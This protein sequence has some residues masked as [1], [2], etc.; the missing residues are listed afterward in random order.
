M[1]RRHGC[2]LYLLVGLV[3]WTGHAS[4]ETPPDFTSEEKQWIKD[5]PVVLFATEP[6]F[7]PV[8][9][10]ENG[11]HAGIVAEYLKAIAKQSGLRFQYVPTKNWEEAQRA[12]REG[13]V[14]LL[15]NV[16]IVRLSTETVHQTLLTDPYY[17]T[18]TVIVTQGDKPVALN[19]RSLDGKVIATTAAYAYIM[20]HR[21]PHATIFPVLDS[22]SALKAVSEGKAEAAVGTEVV[23]APMLR[24]KYAGTMGVAGSLDD[25]P[26]VASMGVRRDEPLLYS[27]MRKS[28]GNL[29]AVETDEM[30]E[31][32]LGQVDYG[33]PSII[34]ILRYRTPELAILGLFIGLLGVFA[35][36]T[37]VA[38]RK[39]EKSE[40]AKSRFLAVMSHEIR[41]PMNAVLASIEMLLRT[42]LDR[43]QQLFA[44]TA[45][46]AA[47]SLLS[48]LDD[49]L[50][51]SKLDAQRLDL[52]RVP[53]DVGALALNVAD[54]VRTRAS[55]KDIAVNV[56]IDNPHHLD[57]LIDPTRFRQVVLNLLT[58]ALKFTEHG[59]ITVS[60]KVAGIQAG[61]GQGNLAV[62]VSDTGIG[63]APDQQARLFQA[64]TQ[65]DSSTT[66][67]YGGT[68]LGLT[69]CKELVELMGGHIKLDSAVGI[70]T[71][72]SFVL[73]V[74][75][76]ERAVPEAM[77]PKPSP[78]HDEV[79]QAEAFEGTVL[80][81]DDHPD[82][83]FVIGEQLRD[84]GIKP[85]SVSDGQAALRAIK[86]QS[87]ALV[88]M[89]C[90]MPEMDGYKTTQRI[91]DYEAA[92]HLA[93]LPVIAIS[94]ATDAAHQ[95]T[96]MQS[97]MD[98]ILT[99]PLR[100]NELH[101]MLQMWL[102]DLPP[103]P[104][105]SEQR[106]QTI[107]RQAL[108]RAALLEDA[109]ALSHALND[110]DGK[111][112]GQLAHRIKGAASIANLNDIGRLAEQLETVIHSNVPDCEV[113]A[114]QIWSRLHEKILKLPDPSVMEDG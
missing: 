12:F 66:R 3:L 104:E 103:Q 48:L 34:S 73:P 83:R 56:H 32:A 8:D 80:V 87:F 21:F 15:P 109:E 93:H 67:R 35:Y 92:H 55:G 65:A 72:V 76:L 100:L 105:I 98:G 69:I 85:V 97:G 45:S 28:L 81:V 5:H 102:G 68:G 20:S 2:M 91:R 64:Y 6:H 52:E 18:P 10:M 51:L 25:I 96:C 110:R 75:L 19:P 57:V 60:L 113:D 38:H 7:P 26:F 17:A 82:N 62:Q 24:R 4:A 84:L 79:A 23:F 89:D 43:R 107:D 54:M 101:D 77:G 90:H 47:E 1:Q 61:P 78:S 88:L 9:A 114:L 106:S 30:L 49:V 14:D 46:T 74:E 33:A 40:L 41:T 70:G 44:N 71:R 29:S 16:S 86:K 36:R 58:N 112:A 53:T 22:A 42:S 50:D 111:M 37:R 11:K 59:H 13:R 39:A 27:V 95:A 94:A 31:N 63:I 99:K 108:Y